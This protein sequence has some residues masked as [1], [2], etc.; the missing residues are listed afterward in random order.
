MEGFS[1]RSALFERPLGAPE[2]VDA[3]F[4]D[5]GIEPEF[6]QQEASYAS[7]RQKVSA[8]VHVART[9][10]DDA[11]VLERV[12]QGLEVGEVVVVRTTVGWIRLEPDTPFLELRYPGVN[13]LAVCT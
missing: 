12:A 3:R 5:E 6:L 11:H 4:E 8:R 13:I 2:V 7:V 9:Q 10:M 1:G